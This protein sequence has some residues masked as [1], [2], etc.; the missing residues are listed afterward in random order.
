MNRRLLCIAALLG[1]FLATRAADAHF[2]WLVV[3]DAGK[4]NFYFGETLA[5]RA[6]KL[7]ASLEAA[8]VQTIAA[9]NPAKKL[10]LAKVETD[11]FI[12]LKSTDAVDRNSTLT[13]SVTFGIYQGARLNYY[14]I[15]Q[16]GKLPTERESLPKLPLDLQ[17]RVV[18]TDK[19]ADVFVLWQG[20]PFADQEVQLFDSKGK[21]KGK[22]S[23]NNDGKASFSS[24][25]LSSGLNGLMLGHTVKGEKGDFNG[26]AY[27]SAAHYLTVTFHAAS[28]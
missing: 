16:G 5:E 6:Y 25:Q 26:K 18:S 27:E 3:D 21:L 4:A 15:H 20:K 19:G 14:T 23:T 24:E 22:V 11:D 1:V 7:P 12:G 2:P 13:S 10:A 9:D 17:A 8:E 28:K